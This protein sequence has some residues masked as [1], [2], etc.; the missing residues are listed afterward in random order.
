ME[1][2]SKL[3]DFIASWDSFAGHY[4]R[5]LT[6]KWDG[7]EQ[8][9]GRIEGRL[10]RTGQLMHDERFDMSRS[11]LLPD[12]CTSSSSE[13]L[14]IDDDQS[15]LVF[16]EGPQQAAGKLG[17]GLTN[18]KRELYTATPIVALYEGDVS[19]QKFRE[20]LS[21]FPTCGVTVDGHL[22]E[23]C[24]EG[25]RSQLRFQGI[26]CYLFT[27]VG[28]A[29]THKVTVCPQWGHGIVAY[30]SKRDAGDRY[31]GQL[32]GDMYEGDQARK[33]DS[34][35]IDSQIPYGRLDDSCVGDGN[36]QE[37]PESEPPER[38]RADCY[39]LVPT[40]PPLGIT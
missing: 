33:G 28:P 20:V 8:I 5:D 1:A 2:L 10:E 4:V 15:L 22:G 40:S 29:G 18:L 3:N 35:I 36:H 19:A 9:T 21:Q 32:I 16:R 27:Y 12:I 7:V 13:L 14:S 23:M 39:N 17:D 37:I 30:A 25:Q 38:R 34:F 31:A 24:C 11:Q 26:E 6:A